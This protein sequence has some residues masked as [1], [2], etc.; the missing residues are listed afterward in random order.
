[1]AYGLRAIQNK[2]YVPYGT[3]RDAFFILD[4]SY[5][6]GRRTPPPEEQDKLPASSGRLLQPKKPPVEISRSRSAG[7][8]KRSGRGVAPSA[9]KTWQR[10]N[11]EPPFVSNDGY[12]RWTQ[13][14]AA[15]RTGGGGPCDLP[16][17]S[18]SPQ[19]ALTSSEIGAK[20]GF[21]STKLGDRY[22]RFSMPV[23][24]VERYEYLDSQ[25][26]REKL[27]DAKADPV[28]GARRFKVAELGDKHTF[29]SEPVGDQARW[30]YLDE[31]G[32]HFPKVRLKGRRYDRVPA[33]DKYPYFST[34][35]SDAARFAFVDTW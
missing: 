22:G 25:H 6:N 24:A 12:L 7:T 5:R 30:D 20:A 15:P 33:R 16:R 10:S 8:A 23:N 27:A 13:T 35:I 14:A 4:P 21:D 28:R 3:G 9:V 2:G 31:T 1:M 19:F 26:S 11:E 29:L 32:T 34:P 17:S 18:S